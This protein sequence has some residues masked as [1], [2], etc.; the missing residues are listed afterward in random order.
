[1]E[2]R[3]AWFE[4][5]G[6]VLEAHRLR[7]RTQYDMEMLRETGPRLLP[8]LRR[9]IRKRL[10]ARLTAAGERSMRRASSSA[11][12]LACS[13]RYLMS[14]VVHIGDIDRRHHLSPAPDR[15]PWPKPVKSTG[16]PGSSARCHTTPRIRLAA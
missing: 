16:R 12:R 13:R 11:P 5:N 10:A 14:L 2:E 8:G 7:Q 4:E 1:M 3:C 6:K 15:E 9:E